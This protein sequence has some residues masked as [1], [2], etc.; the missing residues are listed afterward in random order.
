MT[1]GTALAVPEEIRGVLIPLQ[2]TQLLLPNAAVAEVIGYR[3]P[4]EA[5][6]GAGWLMGNIVWRQRNLPLIRM[7]TLLGQEAGEGGVR[8]RIVVCHSLNED[9]RRPFF[10]FVAAAIPRLVRVREELL[11]GETLDQALLEAPLHA[12]VLF[13]GLPALIPD[14]GRIEQL[15]TEIV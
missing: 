11:Q 6:S 7:E 9:A 2:H 5:A 10:G 15:L 1:E 13:D 8:Q 12:Q 4:D 14:L 3:E